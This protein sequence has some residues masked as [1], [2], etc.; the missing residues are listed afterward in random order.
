[1]K[2]ILDINCVNIYNYPWI[3][4]NTAGYN[5]ANGL[6]LIEGKH[7]YDFKQRTEDLAM[8]RFIRI[9]LVPKVSLGM[10]GVEALFRITRR[11]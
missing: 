1:V 2:N 7:V 5:N 11:F 6:R 10:R 4:C 8:G 9:P 3:C